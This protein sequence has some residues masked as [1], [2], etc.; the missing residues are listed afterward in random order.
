MDQC[1]SITEL[2][3]DKSY[4]NIPANVQR[5]TVK[6]VDFAYSGSFVDVS[7]GSKG[8]KLVS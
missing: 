1:K 4:T 7:R 6:R 3:K 2:R 8:R 5:A